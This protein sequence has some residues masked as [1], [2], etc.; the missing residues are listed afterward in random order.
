MLW[1]LG[2]RG[3]SRYTLE[4]ARSLAGRSDV[5][6]SLAVSR[7]AD[8]YDDMIALGVPTLSVD[9]YSSLAG[10]AA[11]FARLPAVAAQL[12]N[13]LREQRVEIALCAM[14]HLW[15][16]FLAGAIKRAGAANV[17]VVHDAAPHPGENGWR[18][19]L[20]R[21]DYRQADL[22]VS[23]TGSVRDRL[24][25]EMGVPPG[26]VILSAHGPLRYGSGG[27][28]TLGAPPYQLL[29]FGRL[30][31]Y[32]GIDRLIEAMRL[33]EEENFPARLRLVGQGPL[34]IESLPGNTELDR[35][36]V[37]DEEI[38]GLFAQSD[39]LVLPYQEASQSGV[40]AIA[41]HLGLPPLVTP[42][43]GLIEQVEGGRSGFVADDISARGLAD[44]IKR[45]FGDSEAY[46]RLSQILL[47]AGGDSQ[48]AEIAGKLVGDLHKWC[49]LNRF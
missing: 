43:G 6:L 1:N 21:N 49:S 10:F 14:V 47:G 35:R 9:T 7:Q 36:W 13:F 26:K 33:L 25:A 2:Q 16:P 46:R 18:R 24:S 11:G 37:G 48:W 41:Q 12:G 45:A 15:N 30:L 5:R 23:L 8:I 4:L 27:M 40:L 19:P 34:K 44:A 42:V 38:P 3:G 29:L 32:K 20:M 17:L 31:P 22:L 28:R 39:L